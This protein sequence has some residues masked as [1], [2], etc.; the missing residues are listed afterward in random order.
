V[1]IFHAGTTRA[2][3]GSLHVAGGRVLGVTA[4]GDTLDDALA[5]CYE[6]ASHVSWDGMHYR[7]DIGRFKSER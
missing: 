1:R 2:E 5:R 4:T 7:R 3:D 6:S